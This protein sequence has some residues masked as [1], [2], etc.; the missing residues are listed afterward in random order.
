MR[1]HCLQHSD[2]GGDIHLPHWALSRGYDWST[3]LVHRDST[4]PQPQ[5]VDC[6]VVLGGPMSAWED[7]SHPWLTA[8]KHL[9]EVFIRAGRPI[10]GICLGAQLLAGVLGARVYPG[11]HSEIGWFQVN[12]TRQA[13]AHPLG[14]VFPERFDTFLWHG[15]TFDIPDGAVHLASSEATPH[16][17]FAWERVLALQFHLEVRP[18]WVKRLALR[19]AEQLVAGD[20]VQTA[21]QVLSKTQSL[22]Q[23]NNA[24]LERVLDQWL[25]LN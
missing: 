16:Q 24:L 21:A 18:D 13:L 20:H 23:S 25:A 17:A 6:L 10:L 22:Y 15:D 7:A 2:L 3:T 19:D 14:S 9:L 4:L 8:E 12:A 11:E 1:I 5:E